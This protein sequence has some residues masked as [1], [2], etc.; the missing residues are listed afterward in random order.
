M[1][2]RQDMS[3]EEAAREVGNR[4]LE[5]GTASTQP[6]MT[7]DEFD[8]VLEERNRLLEELAY[9]QEVKELTE[10]AFANL[11]NPK[12]IKLGEQAVEDVRKLLGSFDPFSGALGMVTA[13]QESEKWPL[14]RNIPTKHLLFIAAVNPEVPAKHLA[15]FIQALISEDTPLEQLTDF[16]AL[17]KTNWQVSGEPPLEALQETIGRIQAEEEAK[18]AAKKAK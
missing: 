2:K 12:V 7:V 3:L 18:K 13:L 17:T 15:A 5:L 10:K 14:V 9:R 6:E 16:V 8:S 4:L 11:P 1:T